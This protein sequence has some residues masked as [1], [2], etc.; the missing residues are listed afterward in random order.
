MMLTTAKILTNNQKEFKVM[1]NVLTPKTKTW[2]NN[3]FNTN[4]NKNQ[5]RAFT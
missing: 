5:V 3:T 4:A 1:A 2:I